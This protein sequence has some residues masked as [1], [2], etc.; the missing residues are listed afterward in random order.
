MHT[1]NTAG[2][3][4]DNLVDGRLKLGVIA[5]GELPENRRMQ[6]PSLTKG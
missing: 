4:A 2:N 6:N 5:A 3:P 1:G